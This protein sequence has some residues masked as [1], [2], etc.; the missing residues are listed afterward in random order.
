MQDVAAIVVAIAVIDPKSKVLVSDCLLAKLNGAP[1]P[2]SCN[3][4][5]GPAA[6]VDYDA[7]SMI[8][9]GQLLTAWRTALDTNTVG[10]PQPAISGVRL[11][12]RYFYLYQ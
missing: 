11:Y 9:P 1:P 7:A 2:P 4:S 10:L 5:Q 3:Q 8:T 12:E 6:L